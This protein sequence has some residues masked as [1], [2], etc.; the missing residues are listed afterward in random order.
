MSR[1]LYSGKEALTNKD[2]NLGANALKRLV[3][4]F[5]ENPI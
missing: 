2:D 3:A 4:E 1:Y 5:Y